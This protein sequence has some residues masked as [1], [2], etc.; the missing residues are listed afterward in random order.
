[1]PANLQVSFRFPDEFDMMFNYLRMQ[2]EHF[3]KMGKAMLPYSI[4]VGYNESIVE[5]EMTDE[6]W[7]NPL[8]LNNA[9]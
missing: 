7:Q 8:G 3:N 5:F 1:M 4:L 6:D 2:E 9:E